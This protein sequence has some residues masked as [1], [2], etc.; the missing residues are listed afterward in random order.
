M[1]TFYSLFF[2]VWMR[3]LW[4]RRES[5]QGRAGRRRTGGGG[6]PGGNH[7]QRQAGEREGEARGAGGWR[8]GAQVGE[9]RV[10][11]VS[12]EVIHRETSGLAAFF[13][14]PSVDPASGGPLTQGVCVL[15]GVP[16]EW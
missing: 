10:F 14:R 4:R 5:G 6:R 13:P 8:G 12:R 16:W 2:R 1:F 3:R 15:G 7:S 11:P 9:E